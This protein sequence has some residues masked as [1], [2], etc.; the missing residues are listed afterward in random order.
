MKNMEISLMHLLYSIPVLLC[1][2]LFEKRD[3][4]IYFIKKQKPNFRG[5]FFECFLH[6]LKSSTSNRSNF[7]FLQ[8]I[9]KKLP[10]GNYVAKK[11][12]KENEERS[13]AS[14]IVR[15]YKNDIDFHTPVFMSVLLLL[16]SCDTNLQCYHSM[17][18]RVFKER[19][20]FVNSHHKRTK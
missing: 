4:F 5:Y 2:F 15:T 1:R 3:L 20:N 11:R 6:R 14:N 7:F 19:V 10:W 18:K 17:C 12:N 8:I 13:T 16:S 9:H